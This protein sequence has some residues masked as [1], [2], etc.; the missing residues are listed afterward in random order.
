MA[1]FQLDLTEEQAELNFIQIIDNCL[2][3]IWPGILE[4][5]HKIATA[6]R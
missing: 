3:D 1:K 5:A 2:K 6:A 4:F